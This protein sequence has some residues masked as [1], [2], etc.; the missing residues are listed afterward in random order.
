[1]ED[2]RM[3]IKA[4]ERMSGL[5]REAGAVAAGFADA[6]PVP[7][8][9]TARYNAMLDAGCNAGMAYMANHP[10]VRRDP[11]LLL[12]GA[13]SVVSVA[14]SFAPPEFR[15]SEKPMI[16]CYAYGDDYHDVL[17]RRLKKVCESMKDEF[18]GEYRICIDS[19]PVHERYWAEKA[20]IGRRLDNGMLAVPGHGCEVFLAEI[21]TTLQLG[22]GGEAAAPEDSMEDIC[23]HCGACRRA[24]PAGALG[25]DGVVDARRCLSYLTIEHHGEWTDPV[26]QEA[27]A[28]Q[29]EQ[30][31]LFGCDIC[32][33]VCPLNRGLVPTRIEEFQPR[34]EIM[35]IDAGDVLEMKQEDF[36]RIFARS[37]IKRAKLAGLQRNCRNLKR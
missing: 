7:D 27:M 35:E 3:D 26:Y 11:R 4:W 36:S 14:F 34:R 19:A 18:G 9:E 25:A 29:E 30:R 37:P 28:A 6:G 8:D 21:V 15:D 2:Y 5:L 23:L 31:A 12:D 13:K 32:L 33:R 20:G 16:A 10:D 22:E 24:C 17:S 1:M